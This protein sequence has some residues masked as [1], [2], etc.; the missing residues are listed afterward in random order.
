VG[1]KSSGDRCQ[2]RYQPAGRQIAAGAKIPNVEVTPR[3]EILERL[4]VL[5]RQRRTI[6]NRIPPHDRS[7]ADR[8]TRQPAGSPSTHGNALQ[9]LSPWRASTGRR[10]LAHCRS[11]L[12]RW[13]QHSEGQR[14]GIASQLRQVMARLSRSQ[15]AGVGSR[16]RGVTGFSLLMP[17]RFV[18]GQPRR[19]PVRW[20][21]DP[22]TNRTARCSMPLKSQGPRPLVARSVVVLL[23]V[24]LKDLLAV[25]CRFAF[26]LVA[27]LTENA[28]T[29]AWPSKMVD[30]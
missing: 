7:P 29:P 14:A 25:A 26:K 10:Q 28:G 20:Q 11:P 30:L 13:P 22:R 8:G 9:L 19:Q 15:F 21:P 12:S 6:R 24:F 16:G 2:Q 1:G 17:G 5:N 23:I 3:R 18:P 27:C 4:T